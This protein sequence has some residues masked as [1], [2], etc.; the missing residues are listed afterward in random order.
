MREDTQLADILDA[1]LNETRNSACCVQNDGSGCLQSS[2]ADCSVTFPF[3]SVT[4]TSVQI[5]TVFWC[6]REFFRPGSNTVK[7][8]PVEVTTISLQEACVA[9]TLCNFRSET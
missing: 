6:F 9:S 5:F 2:R 3:C 8:F 1:Q 7:T 4:V